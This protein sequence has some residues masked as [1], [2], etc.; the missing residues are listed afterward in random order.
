MAYWK[1]RVRSAVLAGPIVELPYW[2]AT[3]RSGVLAGPIVELTCWKATV[4]SDVL[5]G[6]V[7]EPVHWKA[8]SSSGALTVP[9]SSAR[10]AGPV[11]Q[12]RSEWHRCRLH[13]LEGPAPQ[14][15]SDQPRCRLDVLVA[16]FR[17]GAWRR[18]AGAPQLNR[19]ITLECSRPAG[20][21]RESQR[22]SSRLDLGVQLQQ[23]VFGLC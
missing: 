13:L 21:G 19:E 12:W 20:V 15:R 5:A 3:T 11:P 6:P 8:P 16:P 4:R 18:T 22:R 14:R 17:N 23:C 2:K 7:V 9:L 10:T 1:A